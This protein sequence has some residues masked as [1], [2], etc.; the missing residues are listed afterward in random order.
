MEFQEVLGYLAAFL[1]TASFLPQVYKSWKTK[2]TEGL[3]LTMYTVF[4]LGIVC[5]LIYGIFL[6]SLPIILANTITGVS[7]FSLILM[8]L[9][10]K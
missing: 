7:A 2:S 5:W 9:K 4:F 8:K 3:S 10:Y 6:N 1:T